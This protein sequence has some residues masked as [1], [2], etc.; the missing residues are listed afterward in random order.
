MRDLVA[1]DLCSRRSRCDDIHVRV[2]GPQ[3]D[4]LAPAQ[5]WRN[6]AEVWRASPKCIRIVN[7]ERRALCRC[8]ATGK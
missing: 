5:H 2:V 4:L 3:L 1:L 8:D 7:R 6:R